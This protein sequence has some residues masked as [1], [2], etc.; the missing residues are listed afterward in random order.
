M[1]RVERGGAVEGG[2]QGRQTVV[3]F[4]Y[5]F[6]GHWVQSAWES[7]NPPLHRVHVDESEQAA[8]LG[9]HWSQVADP[10][11]TKTPGGQSSHDVVPS[12]AVLAEHSV[13]SPL[14]SPKPGRH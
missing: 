3:P 13:Q 9:S 6:S 10:A 11:G 4:E 1:Q 5:V 12:E 2:R 8:Q 7:P 14:V